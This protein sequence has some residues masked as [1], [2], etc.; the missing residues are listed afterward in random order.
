MDVRPDHQTLGPGSG[1]LA[2]RSARPFRLR[3]NGRAVAPSDRL[4]AQP[5]LEVLRN[6]LRLTGAKRGCNGGGAPCGA[7]TVLV[8]GRTVA[9]CRTM[10]GDAHD[11]N[12]VTIEGLAAEPDNRVIAAFAAEQALGCGDCWPGI[13]LAAAALL[14][15][16]WRPSD[17]EIDEAMGAVS[18]RCGALPGVRRAIRRAAGFPPG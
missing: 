8:D 12:I 17:A 6:E 18:C 13:V 14:A 10:A 11:K 2:T 5:L 7:C 3:V 9:S 4:A 16:H 1:G 15:D